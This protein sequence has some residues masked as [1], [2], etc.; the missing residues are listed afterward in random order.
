MQYRR[1][2]VPAITGLA[3]LLGS[4]LAL[5]LEL[6]VQSASGKPLSDVVL[7]V[8][9]VPAETNTAAVM[10]QIDRQF[11]PNVLVV[12]PQTQVD[13][14]NSDDVRHHV[15]SFSPANRFEL[16][17]FEGTEA[18]PVPFD[19]AGVVVLGCNIHD[20]MIGY[21]LVDARRAAVS[22]KQGI[23]QLDLSPGTHSLAWW[24][25]S[26]GEAAP[27]P[28]G[29]IALQADATSVTVPVSDTAKP[30][31]QPLSPLQQR[32]RKATEHAAH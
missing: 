26:L 13:F 2:V 32:F 9:G 1:I 18:P 15:Y 25:P 12:A 11:Q 20:Q 31:E 8:E 28:L 22:D 7:L 17:L 4:G 30:T 14:P 16:R 29:N 27:Q 5:A 23:A 3:G 19:Q 21:V 10:D 6:K 24:H